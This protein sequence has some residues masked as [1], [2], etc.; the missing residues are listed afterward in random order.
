MMLR[1]LLR[2]YTA[3]FHSCIQGIEMSQNNNE[4]TT[5]RECVWV[6]QPG[7]PH[8]KLTHLDD[9]VHHFCM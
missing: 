1:R 9:V 7:Y 3:F 4:L 5:C 2:L 6:K 8:E